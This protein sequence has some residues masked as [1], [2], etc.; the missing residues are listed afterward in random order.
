M[1][2]V[3]FI[4]DLTLTIKKHNLNFDCFSLGQLQSK[5]WIIDKLKDLNTDLGIVFN[6][7]GWYGMLPAMMF[8]AGIR[9][10]KI[11]SFDIDESCAIIA[12]DMNKS[13]LSSWVFK[14]ITD[15]INNIN[16]KNHTWRMWSS[17]NNRVS[18][19]IIESPNTIINTSCE[20]TN[21]DWFKKVQNGQMIII[22]SNDFWDGDGHINCCL[23]MG[24]FDSRY[25]MT[26]TLYTGERVLQKYTRFMKVG[27][28]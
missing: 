23:D 7:C 6:L 8:E 26:T 14:A 9:M 1:N 27:I 11:R 2:F 24:D 13:N 28:K 20:H 3:N 5:Q 17:S 16:F 25:P 18:H 19:G 22:Q 10:N 21:D 4:H 12:D 15:D